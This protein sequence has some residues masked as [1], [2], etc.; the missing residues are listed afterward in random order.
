MEG[1]ATFGYRGDFGYIDAGFETYDREIQMYKS[2]PTSTG[3]QKLNTNQ[4]VLNGNINL[5]EK[6][7]LEPVISYQIHS[8]KEYET[9]YDKEI[10]EPELYWKLNTFQGDIRLHYDQSRNFTGTFG[11]AVMDMVNKSLGTEKL[12]PNFHTAGFGVYAME[13]YNTERFTVSGG[14]RFDVKN[15]NI[16]NTIMEED[17]SGAAAH[18]ITP[19]SIDFNALSGSLG[20]VYRPSDKID[21]F[22]NIGRGWRSPSEYEMY[23]DGVH[24]GTNRYERGLITLDPSASPT[25]ES[26]LN[27]DFGVRVRMNKLNIEVSLFNNIVS[28][29]IYPAPT[30]ETDPE[31]GLQIYDIKQDRSE[32]RGIEYSVQYQPLDFLLISLNGD[33]L[34]TRN[35]STGTAVPLTPPMKN[36]FEVKFQKHQ[37][38]F[39]FNPYIKAG[40]K[41]VNAQN[42]VYVKEAKTEGYMLA[43]AGMGVDFILSKMTI[44]VDL[45]V[46]NL[47]DGK[48][49]DHLSRYKMTAMNP[50]RS[51]NLKITVPFQ[52]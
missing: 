19:R 48:Y 3:S 45:N 51:I 22:T 40:L 6:F 24:E 18:E 39:L 26:S 52:Y 34:Y 44:S 47:F 1:G 16:R 20:L 35:N 17:T 42:E 13:K 10:D 38:G 11:I 32:F 8:R 36:Y 7:H 23:V 46:E 25:I 30:E 41:I 28:N 9:A 50:G 2:D 12:I 49:V 27:I 33:Y 5:G 15:V 37:I 14:L 43:D 29:F 4:I 21:I 31:S